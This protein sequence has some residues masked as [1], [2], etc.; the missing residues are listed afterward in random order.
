[1]SRSEQCRPH[2]PTYALARASFITAMTG[3][4]HAR[5]WG[6]ARA[7]AQKADNSVAQFYAA[8][9]SLFTLRLTDLE[10]V[11]N[12]TPEFCLK[13]S[14]ITKTKLIVGGGDFSTTIGT[15]DI[16]NFFYAL[17]YSGAYRKKYQGTLSQGFPILFFPKK[18]A[19]ASEMATHGRQLIALHLLDEKEA[20]NLAKPETRFVGK[21]EARVEKGYPKY[22]NGKVM[23]NASCHFEDVTPDVWDFHIGGYQ[24]CRKWLKDR[25]GKGGKNPHPGRVL[26]DADILHYRRITIA[27]R[28]TISLMKQIDDTINKHGGWPDAFY[29]APPPPP[30]IEEI[31]QADECHELEY[32]S[33]FQWDV[34]ENR[35]NKDLQKPCL[36]TIAAFLNT[37]GGTLVIGVTD[38][39]EIFGL[40]QDLKLTKGTTDQFEQTFRQ[41]MDNC[42]GPAFAP[43]CKIRF[44]YAPDGKQVCVI[45]VEKGKEPAF[46]KFQN[47]QDFFIRNGNATK[48]LTASEQHDYIRQHFDR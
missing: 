23:I 44:A 41:A 46:L 34:K 16:L 26:T 38:G 42:I 43:Y 28:D 1:M 29:V 32:K 21:G 4:Y 27:L 31:I 37:K 2:G 39:K 45:E 36:K 18:L 19:L 30:T 15:E 48:A 40:E 24:V 9:W 3:R 33:T 25:A 35:K 47:Q 6:S 5:E 22:E 14:E 8:I 20:P 13:W 17:F 7:K 11:H 12:F 10:K